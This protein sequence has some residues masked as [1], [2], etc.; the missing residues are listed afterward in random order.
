MTHDRR[1]ILKLAAAGAGMSALPPALTAALAAP[2]RT[3]TG[4]IKDIEHV[5]IFMQENRSFDHYY[6]S[7][8]GVRGFSDPRALRLPGGKSVFQQ[9]VR[10]GAKE[11]VAPFHFDST[12]TSAQV[13]GSLDHSWKGSQNKWRNWDVWVP[14]KSPLTMGYFTRADIPFYYALADAFTICDA[15]HCSI[16]GP[17]N[18]NRLFLWTGTSGLSVGQM[19]ETPAVANP[20]D[21]PNE[22][23]DVRND[24]PGFAAL[25]WTTYPERLTKAGVSWK[26]YQEFDN[27]GDNALAY[28][29]QFRAGAPAEALAQARSWVAGSNS[30]NAKLSRGEHLIAAF[31]EDVKQ[32]RLAQVSWIVAPYIACEHPKATP[33]YGE[34]LTAGLLEAL[35]ANPEVFAKTAFILNYDENDG[36]F[37]HMPPPVPAL[38]ETQG[39]TNIATDGEVYFGEP[40][41]FGPRVP[42]IIVSP[43]TRGG[44]VNSQLSDHTSIIRFLEK[45]FGVMEPN[46][47]PWR[48]AMSGDL[49]SMF[50]FAQAQNFP[51]LPST[52]GYVAAADAQAKLPAPV[53]LPQSNLPRQEPGQRPARPLPYDLDV[54][55]RPGT[56]TLDFVNRGAAGAA[57]RV[58]DPAHKAGPWD[59]SLAAGTALSWTAPGKAN[60]V[61]QGPN[62]FRRA[63]VLGGPL[64][65]SAASGP[66]ALQLILR[67][68]GPDAMEFRI[69]DRYANRIERHKLAPG[70]QTKVDIAVATYDHWY[71]VEVGLAD[72]AL[73]HFAGHI[74]TGKP[75]KSDPAIGRA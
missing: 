39:A 30:A 5:V 7:L 31:A 65:V 74:E 15:Y 62:G 37:D 9:P 20:P 70:E 46:I 47:S 26:L 24:A 18:P 63:L 40:A 8:R 28:F 12:T 21:E 53:V 25:K 13:I 54:T 51:P 52:A 4:T 48:R 2:A 60:Y 11:T 59:I 3:R 19:S 49:T 36:F 32:D 68:D 10:P 75:S 66:E 57:F 38:H 33:G 22:S 71:D 69:S 14:E 72:V 35:A 43:W 41:G 27:Y 23:A 67:N 56:A 17:T 1:S 73:W 50:D 6:G 29:E 64:Q 44:F 16:F 34:A 58:T 55:A 61:V 45:R 42:L